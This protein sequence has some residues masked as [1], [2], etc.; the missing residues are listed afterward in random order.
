MSCNI[1]WAKFHVVSYWELKIEKPHEAIETQSFWDISQ[2][3]R[4]KIPFPM[5]QVAHLLT[6]KIRPCQKG[7]LGHDAPFFRGGKGFNLSVFSWQTLH[8]SLVALTFSEANSTEIYR[9]PTNM[10]YSS[11]TNK[12]WRKNRNTYL[13]RELGRLRNTLTLFCVWLH[14]IPS[15]R[16]SNGVPL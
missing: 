12:Y 6:S 1:R 9:D 4:F 16:S 3:C 5:A 2:F 10:G 15:P 7:A 8:C 14:L 11:Y 13:H